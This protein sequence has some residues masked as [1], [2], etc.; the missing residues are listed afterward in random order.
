MKCQS[1]IS[2]TVDEEKKLF[3]LKYVEPPVHTHSSTQIVE[4]VKAK[5]CSNLHVKIMEDDRFQLELP[6]QVN[7]KQF[8][9]KLL[10]LQLHELDPGAMELIHQTYINLIDLKGTTHIF[11]TS[12]FLQFLSVYRPVM[13]LNYAA[14]TAGYMHCNHRFKCQSNISVK[15]DEEKGLFYLNYL[16]PPVHGHTSAEV[17]EIVKVTPRLNCNATIMEDNRFQIDL[18]SKVNWAKFVP[19]LK[20]IESHKLEPNALELIHETFI[21]LIDSKTTIH[22]FTISQ[23]LQFLSVYLPFMRFK[24]TSKTSS[25]LYCAA[26][27]N[28]QSM[29]SVRLD[30]EKRLFSLRYVRPPVHYHSSGEV[31]KMAKVRLKAKP[32][33]NLHVTIIEDERFQL[34]LPAEVNWKEFVKTLREPQLHELEPVALELIHQTFTNLIELRDTIHIFT[35]SQFLQFVSVYVPVMKLRCGSRR[36]GYLTCPYRL[37]CKSTISMTVDEKK[38]LFYL[39]YLK[40]PIHNHSTAEIVGMARSHLSSK[41]ETLAAKIIEDDRFQIEL[42]SKVNWKEFVPKLREPQFHELEESAL[43]M[44]H[45]AYINLIDLKDAIHIFTTSQFLQFLLVYLPVMRLNYTSE[46]S[47]CLKCDYRFNCDS[48]IIVRLD[49]EKGL[50]SLRYL[51]PPFHKHS[52]TEVVEMAK[53]SL[54]LKPLDYLSANIMED[55]RFHIEIPAQA[56]WREFLKTLKEPQLHGLEPD[57]LE[58]IH[59]T[60]NNLINLRNTIHIF[61]TSQFLQFILIYVPVMKL[62]CGSKNVFAYLHCPSQFK[63]MSSIS[64]DIDAEKGLFYLNILK[65]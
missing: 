15:V 24:G 62:H 25:Y 30:K 40:S 63:C 27:F 44:I 46:V 14:T 35:T 20:N 33:E 28:C 60:F 54:R 55:D 3:Y 51:H 6:K 34:K 5:H 12:Q 10:E 56:Y 53:A 37:K 9:P 1:T 22:I 52:T 38:G 23:F 48:K 50:F 65:K 26:E 4:M 8:V 18:P 39:K 21:H 32:I 64:V 42:P 11:T 45:Q 17:V 19:K 59:Q 41:Q 29:I 7:W 2:V 58:L 36:I 43:D 16:R 13:G 49:R 61:T 57:A 31:V 47:C